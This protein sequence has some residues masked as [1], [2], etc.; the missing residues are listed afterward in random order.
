[1]TDRRESAR[2]GRR[3][4]LRLAGPIVIA[5]SAVPLLGIVDTAVIGNTG[6]VVDLG[7][8]ALG[9]LI[10]NFLYWSFGF[11]WMGTTGFTAQAWGAGNKVEVRATLGRALLLGSGIGIALVL[12]Q[13]PI[14]WIALELLSGTRETEELASAYFT[15]RI[16]GAPASLG[17]FCVL[18]TFVGLGRTGQLLKTQLFLNGL[19]IVLDVVLAGVFGLGVRGIALGTAIAEWTTLGLALLLAH[20]ILKESVGVG[21]PFWPWRRMFG[22]GGWSKTLAANADIIVRTLFLLAG[23]AWFTNQGARLGD[24]ILA[25]NHLLLQ[26]ITLS[27]YL[28]DG[29]AHATEVL[30]GRAVGAGQL[31]AFDRAARAATELAGV[32]AVGL[33]CA[34]L[35]VGPA[36]LSALTDLSAVREVS[37]QYLPWTAAYVAVSFAA[38]QLDG[39]FIG[40]TATKEM[41]NASILS[42]GL[43]L[44]ASIILTPRLANLGLWIAFVFYVI[45][46]AVSLGLGYS[47]LRGSIGLSRGPDA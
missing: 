11:L 47:R 27:A 14:A 13:V 6:T 3:D 24:Q 22:A 32:T 8:I 18:G 33:A 25:A 26:I 34:V 19:N 41:R 16:W 36:G 29:Y 4:L 43:F 7:A 5:N 46:R 37:G 28:L 23:F 2:S 20:R 10:F 17:I 21:E 44:V 38:F 15:I 9:A 45:A 42:F 31:A 30:V 12:L 40:A 39:I 1:M 35:L